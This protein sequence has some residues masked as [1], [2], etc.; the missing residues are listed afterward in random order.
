MTK[1]TRMLTY[2]FLLSF[3][4]CTAGATTAAE[5]EPTRMDGPTCSEARTP[6]ITLI[7]SDPGGSQSN[8]KTPLIKNNGSYTLE[9]GCRI[10]WLASDG[11]RRTNV[12]NPALTPGSE[13]KFGPGSVP[14]GAYDCDTV[15][16][17][18][19]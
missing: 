12:V 2:I 18:G 1:T 8:G 5:Q 3:A 4:A 15:H 14:Q 10:E 16:V 6:P 9:A 7:C 13:R 17:Y 19:P 11:D